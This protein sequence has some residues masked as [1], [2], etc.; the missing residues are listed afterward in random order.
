L[1]DYV[2]VKEAKE[3]LK[4]YFNF[5]NYARHHQSLNYKKRNR[6]RT[7]DSCSF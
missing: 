5:Y 2:S 6:S 3:N 4:N 7:F 1:H